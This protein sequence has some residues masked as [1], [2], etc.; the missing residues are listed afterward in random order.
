MGRNIAGMTVALLALA[1]NQAHAAATTGSSDE[2]DVRVDQELQP[3]QPQ[4]EEPDL[5]PPTGEDILDAVLPGGVFHGVMLDPL[6][7]T[8]AAS[9]SS[10]DSPTSPGDFSSGGLPPPL[11]GGSSG[12][13][14]SGGGSSGGGSLLG[15]VPAIPV[16][17]TIHVGGS[18]S[19]GAQGSARGVSRDAE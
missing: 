17:R 12:G 11:D 9:V 13:G 3:A 6:L 7:D 14:A 2:R 5:V 15:E 4:A 1:M 16:S 19:A 10:G 8:G 18:P